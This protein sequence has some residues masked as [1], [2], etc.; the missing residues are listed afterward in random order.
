[1]LE[2]LS[3][4]AR[5]LIGMLALV[6]LALGGFGLA[7][8]TLLRSYL[9]DRV[10]AELVD[11]QPFALRIAELRRPEAFELARAGPEF[12]AARFGA[13]RFTLEAIDD[14]GTTVLDRSGLRDSPDPLPALPPITADDV[15]RLSEPFTVEA[16]GDA[17]FHYRALATL[18]LGERRVVVMAIPLNGDD[19]TIARLLRVEAIVAAVVLAAIFAAGWRVVQVG[20]RPLDDMT[21]TAAAI[22]GGD[23]SH[24]IELH[25]E[26]S[27]EV[28]R[29]GRA[30]NSMLSQIEA[31]F[32][33]R[34]QSEDQ[35]RR[36][37]ADASHELRTP[38]TSI[39]GYAELYRRGALPDTAAVDDAMGRIEDEATRVA[40]LVDDL[41]LLARLDQGRALE[42]EPVDL[43]AVTGDA[44]GDFRAVS[45]AYPIT[46]DHDRE[47][48]VIGDPV[49]LPQIVANLL[50]NAR[51]HTATGTA[52]TVTVRLSAR[53]DDDGE[54]DGEGTID[55]E[56]KAEIRITDA[57]PGLE[58]EVAARIFE[59]SFRGDAIGGGRAHHAGSGL[60]LSI[61]AAIAKAHGGEAIVTSSPG[62]GST[63]IVRLPLGGRPG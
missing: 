20:L 9:L 28:G 31:A 61:V 4:R 63:F 21:D 24:R 2:R 48:V 59:R 18:H 52:V 30:L 43:V 11:A 41:L 23:L 62:H 22:A 1:M 42:Q 60:G 37:V 10:D 6:M 53:P 32:D 57:G 55:G 33:N 49:R 15:D 8:V 40:S 38:L 36:F 47:V 13:S 56:P 19:A 29:L 45:P 51:V 54:G 35:L 25:D 27:D 34:R 12:G 3:L 58:P 7:T 44:I 16:E 46:F 26:R 17:S 39:R 5:L 14:Q 50:D